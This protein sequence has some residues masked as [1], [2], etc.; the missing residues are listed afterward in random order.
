MCVCVCDRSYFGLTHGVHPSA[1][2]ARTPEQAAEDE[3]IVRYLRVSH[4]VAMADACVFEAIK[5]QALLALAPS[6][7]EAIKC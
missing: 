7:F 3:H 6:M 1:F 4:L 5:C 2:R